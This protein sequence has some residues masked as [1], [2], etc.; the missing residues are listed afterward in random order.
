[1]SG[2]TRHV[3]LELMPYLR[4]ELAGAEREA[5]EAHLAACEHCRRERDAFA[6]IVGE[7]RRSGPEPPPVHWGRWR[8]ELR[9]R[10]ERPRG[11]RWWA[12]PLPAVLSLGVASALLAVVWLGIGRVTPPEN[13]ASAPP[14]VA[15]APQTTL[16]EASDPLLGQPL[17]AQIELLE[18]L[19]VIVQLD[20]LAP[21]QEG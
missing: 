5:V 4:G 13:V 18:D 16:V 12:R 8:A 1:M 2:S 20:N 3:E 21:G 9:G 17:A 15:P 7:L 14:A 11:W 6:D 19:D 10:L